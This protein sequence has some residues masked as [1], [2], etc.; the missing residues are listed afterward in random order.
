MTSQNEQITALI[1]QTADS[2]DGSIQ[3]TTAID[4][5]SV[6]DRWIDALDENGDDQTDT[7]A[8]ILE[9]LKAE[10]SVARQNETPDVESIQELLQELIGETQ[11]YMQM[12]EASAQQTELQRLV[13]TLQNIHTQIS[14]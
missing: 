1:E 4:G 3:S 9:D 7:I 10:L 6:I 12:P 5:M 13:S 8:D 14:A 11:S 2:F